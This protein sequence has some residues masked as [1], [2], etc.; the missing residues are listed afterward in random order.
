MTLKAPY[1]PIYPYHRINQPV[2][3]QYIIPNTFNQYIIH[4]ILI[5][6][7]IILLQTTSNIEIQL[8]TKQLSSIKNILGQIIKKNLYIYIPNRIYS[9][10]FLRILH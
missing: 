3:N 8:I 4:Q 9:M 6:Y 10:K 5:P 7:L 1:N 2:I